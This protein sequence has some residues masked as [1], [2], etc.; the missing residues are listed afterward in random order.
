MR[1]IFMCCHPA[2]DPAGTDRADAALPSDGLPTAE[3]AGRLPG[4][5][6]DDGAAA[7]AGQAEDPGRPGS[8]SGVRGAEELTRRLGPVLRVIYLVLNE[9]LLTTGGELCVRTELVEDAE[10]LAGLLAAALPDEPE[11]L[12]LLALIRLHSARWDARID[13]DGRSLV[14][15]A[16]Q[17]RSCWDPQRH[18]PPSSEPRPPSPAWPYQIRGCHRR[19]AHCEAPDWEHT[20]LAAT[21]PALRHA[22]SPRSIPGGQTEPRGRTQPHP[23]SR[24]RRSPTSKHP[25]TPNSTD[26]TCSMPREHEPLPGL[27]R[28]DGAAQADPR[29]LELTENPAER[30]LLSARLRNESGQLTVHDKSVPPADY[31]PDT[32]A[33]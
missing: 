24:R 20:G 31:S 23:R 16:Q 22:P 30:S 21:A 7:G 1:L 15:L 11:P 28:P 26:T 4:A 3:I 9:A 13:A 10:W 27:N 8:G 12:G 6:G 19:A 5:R 17:D 25:R 14:P 32:A 29:A 33:Q 18:R 2:L